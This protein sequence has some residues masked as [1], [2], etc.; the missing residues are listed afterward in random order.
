MKIDAEL[1]RVIAITIIVLLLIAGT[2]AWDW[3]AWR[4]CREAGNPWLFCARVLG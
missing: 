1:G 3:L 4:E 2:V